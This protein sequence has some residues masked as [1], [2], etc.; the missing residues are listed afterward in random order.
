EH[1]PEQLEAMGISGVR[2][3]GMRMLFASHPPIEDRI[4]ALR[5]ERHAAGS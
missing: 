4:A 3:G 5:E 1:M 2:K